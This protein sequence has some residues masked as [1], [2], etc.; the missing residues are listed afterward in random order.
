MLNSALH[1]PHILKVR[2]CG[3]L[4]MRIM[5]LEQLTCWG[6]RDHENKRFCIE[7]M[8]CKNSHGYLSVQTPSSR[9]AST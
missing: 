8:A 7:G 4:K 2:Y 9:T 3:G 5:S 6:S 1:V